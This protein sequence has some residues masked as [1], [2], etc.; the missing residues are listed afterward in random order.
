MNKSFV[1]LVAVIISTGV[2]FAAE[3]NVK[4]EGIMENITFQAQDMA[5]TAVDNVKTGAQKTGIFIKEKSIM[6]GE[7]T[8]KHAKKGAKKAK[9]ATI[10][11]VNQVGNTTA[12]GLKKAG[13]KLQSSAEKAIET[14]DK[15]IENAAP[16]CEC[17]NCNCNENCDCK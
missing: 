12:K 4:N 1:I 3:S 9:N 10:R 15:N 17:I 6:V 5:E 16:K 8:A 11:G 2:V 14:T 7:T 13:E